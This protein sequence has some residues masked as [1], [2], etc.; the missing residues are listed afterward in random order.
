MFVKSHS[1]N[2][3]HV[4]DHL[5]LEGSSFQHVNVGEL[6]L[7]NC[8]KVQPLIPTFGVPRVI[9]IKVGGPYSHNRLALVVNII[10]WPKKLLDALI[11]F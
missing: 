8:S 10:L 11:R 7:A 2:D 5:V 9:H 3:Q 4:P 1:L 6:C